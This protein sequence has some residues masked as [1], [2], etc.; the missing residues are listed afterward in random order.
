MEEQI[1]LQSNDVL[2]D[3]SVLD[4]LNKL[5]D[6]INEDL[7]SDV[8]SD[9]GSDDSYD[10]DE[11]T[12]DD[13]DPDSGENQLFSMM[14]DLVMELQMELEDEKDEE[15][16]QK[17]TTKSTEKSASGLEDEKKFIDGNT[18]NESEVLPQKKNDVENVSTTDGETVNHEPSPV[19][20]PMPSLDSSNF[21]H[22]MSAS[23]RAEKQQRLHLHVKSLLQTCYR[24]GTTKWCYDRRK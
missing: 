15:E 22:T 3:S 7:L 23:E 1:D 19:K 2:F 14:D 12:D 6:E 10:S 17:E 4:S 18:D 24:Y 9:G 16:E 20:L 13:E 5:T 21:N 11:Y 8:D